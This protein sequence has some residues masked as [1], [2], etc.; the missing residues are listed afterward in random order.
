MVK[1]TMTRHLLNFVGVCFVLLGVYQLSYWPDESTLA[2]G[3][4]VNEF[5]H[6]STLISNDDNN[7][8]PSEFNFTNDDFRFIFLGEGGETVGKV[9]ALRSY[10]RSQVSRPST[11][12]GGLQLGVNLDSGWKVDRSQ[13]GQSAFVDRLLKHRRNG[14]FVECGAADGLAFSNSLFF[15][16]T[17]NWTGLLIEA[18]PS[19]YGSLL[20]L[21]RKAYVLNACLSPT[22][23]P[24]RMQFKEAGVLGGL[25]D[26]LES[27]H[28]EFIKENEP[29]ADQRPSVLV[30][31][32][33]LNDVLT[34]IGVRHV[35][36]FSLDVEGA[37]LDILETV[38]WTRLNI[39]VISVE[40]R[41]YGGSKIGVDANATLTKL[42]RLRKFFA[43]TGRFVEVG[44][45]P[46]GA[47]VGGLDVIFKRK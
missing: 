34:A 37:E 18:N 32:F 3:R 31:C 4:H 14:F 42:E 38:D 35:D 33:P 23:R 30:N 17:H 12:A 24:G 7:A 11:V 10:I 25:V 22:R 2:N 20:Q 44:L 29:R 1:T 39:D 45:L 21:N 26:K 41:V 28:K 6:Q 16:L 13:E 36:Y 9:S 27:S 19:E 43:A 40:Y 8:S 47:D 15:E 46:R 5:K